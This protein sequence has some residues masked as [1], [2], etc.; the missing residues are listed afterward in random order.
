MTTNPRRLWVLVT[1]RGRVCWETLAATRN[2]CWWMSDSAVTDLVQSDDSLMHV[3]WDDIW[4]HARR[5]GYH[6]VRVRCEVEP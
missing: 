4:P 1:P 2:D 5:R 3:P 6:F